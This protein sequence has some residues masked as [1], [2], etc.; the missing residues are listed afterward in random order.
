M[1][2]VISVKHEE[3]IQQSAWTQQ[4]QEETPFFGHFFKKKI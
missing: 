2:D 4:K 1:Y 3:D